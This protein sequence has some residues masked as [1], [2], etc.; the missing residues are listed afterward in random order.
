MKSEDIDWIIKRYAE[1]RKHETQQVAQEHFLAYAYLVCRAG[2][3]EQFLKRTRGLLTFYIDSLSLFEN[4]FR[5]A[6]VCW[7]MLMFLL[8]VFSLYLIAD[9]DFRYAG[10]V[11]CTGT[12]IFGTS[13]WKIVWNNWLDTSLLIA[14]YREIID[15]IDNLQS[16][17]NAETAA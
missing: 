13:L 3:V 12:V 6:Q 15:L 4:P 17:S 16:S 14:C 9:A 2:E 7:L 11:L 5:N 10:I 8:F 1:E